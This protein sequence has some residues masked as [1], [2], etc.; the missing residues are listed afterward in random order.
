MCLNGDIERQFEF[1]Q[2]TC[3]QSSTFHGLSGEGDPLIGER[4]VADTFT[5][6]NRVPEGPMRLPSLPLFV[7]TLGGGYFFLPGRRT[8]E[9]LSSDLQLPFTTD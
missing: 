7:H 3:I 1:V 9:Y 5:V 6:P 8:I 4:S 2:Q